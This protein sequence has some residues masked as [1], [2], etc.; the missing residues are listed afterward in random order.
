MAIIIFIFIMKKTAFSISL[1]ALVFALSGVGYALAAGTATTSGDGPVNKTN[2]DSVIGTEITGGNGYDSAVPIVPGIYHL[3]HFQF[4]NDFDYFKMDVK[5]GDVISYS[6]QGAENGVEFNEDTKTFVRTG[7][8]SGD[9][10][11]VKIYSSTRSLMNDV[12]V[13]SAS[14]LSK[15]EM[16]ITDPGTSTIYFLVGT[17]GD[18]GQIMDKNDLF[19]LRLNNPWPQAVETSA[20]SNGTGTGSASNNGQ[21]TGDTGMGANSGDGSNPANT[22]GDGSVQQG[23]AGIFGSTMNLVLLV[24]GILALIILIFIIVMVMKKKKAPVS[25]AVTP[26]QPTQQ[27]PQAPVTPPTTP[28]NPP[29]VPPTITQ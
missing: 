22:S 15:S 27:T 24:G 6:V 11:S 25:A 5:G 14:G 1:L 29:Q 12:G 21:S 23:S 3:S 13:N 16:T 10:A 7:N 20:G 18:R 19:T 4:G 28:V 2:T 8:H 17:G 26:V 9:W